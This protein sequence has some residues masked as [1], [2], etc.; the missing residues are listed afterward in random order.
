MRI[1]ATFLPWSRSALACTLGVFLAIL[2]FALGPFPGSVAEATVMRD[3]GLEG[4]VSESDAIVL[5]RVER[6]QTRVVLGKD[7]RPQTFTH[8]RVTEWLKGRPG[9][10]NRSSAPLGNRPANAAADDVVVVQELGGESALGTVRVPG[11][12][13]FRMGEQVL[14]FLAHHPDG[15]GRY[16]TYGM[17]QG[18]FTVLHGAPGVPDSVRRDLSSIT[19]ART[20]EQG[21]M[22]LVAGGREPAMQLEEVLRFI[23]ERITPESIAPELPESVP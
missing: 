18:K 5:G 14:L 21:P 8:V 13:E 17:V 9:V 12:P 11:I 19:V 6:S 1:R 15:G 16:R 4:L 23:R 10:G 2:G 3:V 22:E 7:A 20:E